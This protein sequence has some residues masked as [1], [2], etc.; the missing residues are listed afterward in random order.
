MIDE[1]LLL[2]NK[3]PKVQSPLG[4]NFYIESYGSIVYAYFELGELDNAEKYI[5]MIKSEALDFWNLHHLEQ[6]F[7]DVKSGNRSFNFK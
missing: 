1:L 6:L 7:N 4:Y 5:N 3:Y 2:K